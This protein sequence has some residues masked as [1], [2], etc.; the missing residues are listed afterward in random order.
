MAERNK[1]LAVLIVGLLVGFG[2]GRLMPQE[3]ED[4]QE[5]LVQTQED[6]ALTQ[7]PEVGTQLQASIAG[8]LTRSA[9]DRSQVSKIDVSVLVSDQVSGESVFV[10]SVEVDSKTWVAVQANRDGVPGN[11]LGARRIEAPVSSLE[12]P[13]LRTTVPGEVYF[14]LLQEDNGNNQYDL[15]QDPEIVDTIGNLIFDTFVA[16]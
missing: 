12:I 1:L 8:A 9:L 13:L 10:D 2:V 14:V 16:K 5:E 4:T 6:V 7:E 11:V 15:Y 3:T